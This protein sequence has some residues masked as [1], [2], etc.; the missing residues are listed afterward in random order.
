VS[1]SKISAYNESHKSQCVTIFQSN[2]PKFFDDEELPLFTA[3]LDG[4]VTNYFVLEIEER[5]LA[6]GGWLLKTEDG[7]AGLVWGMV[8]ADFHGRRFG[9]W[10]LAWRLGQIAND[11]K[12]RSIVMDT[13]QHTTGFFEKFRFRTTKRTPDGYG[14][15]LHR[16][17]M[18][19]E[20]N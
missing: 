5:V 16:H 14:P 9:T 2:Q 7:E 15:G 3:F 1:P 17:D 6:C 8:H 11:L 12:I 19:L 10:L 13:S 4:L 20:L 18:V